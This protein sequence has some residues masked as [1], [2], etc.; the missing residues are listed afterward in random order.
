MQLIKQFFILSLIVLLGACSSAAVK[1]P[2]DQFPKEN[3]SELYWGAIH[4]IRTRH[5]QDAIS[6]FE[7]L[8][9][10]YPFGK[11]SEKGHLYIIYA[12]Y[13]AGQYALGVT[14]T[15]RYIHLHPASQGT[16]YAYFMK[17]VMNYQQY[18][19][20]ME[21]YFPAQMADRD[22][23][24]ARESFV[25]FSNL[26]TNYPHD[27][28]TPSAVQYMI[29]LRNLMAAQTLD[30]AQYYLKRKAYVAAA[31]RA[32]EVILHYQGTPSVPEALLV[33]SKAYK[34]LDLPGISLEYQNVYDYNQIAH[35]S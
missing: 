33:A 14:A 30:I 8:D 16:G 31:D 2:A 15:D 21:R 11:Y 5:Y 22:L 27:I 1:N 26:S 35:N 24:P 9:A 12:Y 29:Y 32:N 6:R 18:L 20:V 13:M 19:S 23:K 28:Y 10:R 34:A 4:D 25:Y 3:D 7:T 17:G